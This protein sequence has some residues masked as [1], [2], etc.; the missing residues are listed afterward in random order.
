[1]T[2]NGEPI[3]SIPTVQYD[4]GRVRGFSIRIATAEDLETFKA[5][6]PVEIPELGGRSILLTK[7]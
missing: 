1:M 7:K 4:T 5:D 2:H 6:L 3:P